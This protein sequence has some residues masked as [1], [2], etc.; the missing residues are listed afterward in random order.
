MGSKQIRYYR[1]EDD[2]L[3]LTTPPVTRAGVTGTAELIWKK[4]ASAT[5]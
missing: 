1:F 5:N 3:I 4:V 2:R